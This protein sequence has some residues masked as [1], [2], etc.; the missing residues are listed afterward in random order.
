MSA[1]LNELKKKFAVFGLV[2]L[3]MG[4]LSLVTLP[5]E[6]S[7]T[8]S[9]LDDDTPATVPEP[10]GTRSDAHK[11][12]GYLELWDYN[13]NEPHDGV[14]GDGDPGDYY[15]FYLDSTYSYFSIYLRN[16]YTGYRLEYINTTLKVG[17]EAT[18]VI[19]VTSKYYNY[20]YMY[21]SYVRE[22]SYGFKIDTTA[23]IQSFQLVLDIEFVAVNENYERTSRTGRIYFDI[24]LSSRLRTNDEELT[25]RGRDKSGYYTPIYSG[26]RNMYITLMDAYSGDGDLEDLTVN[27][28][29][30]STFTIE[31]E[32][33]TF[34]DFDTYYY[35][36]DDMVWL[37]DDAGSVDKMPDKFYGTIEISYRKDE[38][39]IKERSVPIALEIAKTPIINLD[40]QI[41]ESEIGSMSGVDYISNVAIYQGSTSEMFSLKFQ[42]DGNLDLKDVKIELYTDNAAFFFKSKFYYDEGNYAYKR[43]YGKTI[44]LG[45]IDVGHFKTE[46]I[47]TEVIKNLP[48]GLYKIPIK[49]SAKYLESEHTEI[50]VEE[51]D[52]HET[53][54][55]ARSVTNEGFTPFLL[56][57]VIEGDNEFDTTEPDM[58]A[59]TD[60]V[61][62]PGMHNVKLSVELTNLENYRLNNVNV[63]IDVGGSSP[64]QPLNEVDRTA[65]KL[66][67]LEK[68]FAIYS[69]SD[70]TF[71]N[72]YTVHFMVDIYSEA[73]SGVNEVPITITCLDPY[74]QERSTLVNVPLNINPIPPRIILIDASTNN[75]EPDDTFT[76]K[77]RVYN[78]GGCNAKNVRLL[79][80]GSSN[81]FTAEKSI[82]GPKNINKEAESEFEF[83]I[84]A[85]EVEP[86][87]IYSSSVLVGYEDELGNLISFDDSA[88]QFITL[89][90][91][92]PEPEEPWRINEGIAL[93]ILG[94]F[95]LFSTLLF[96]FFRARTGRKTR[97]DTLSGGAIEP[98]VVRPS[99]DDKGK[100]KIDARFRK[101]SKA[102][103]PS[104]PQSRGGDR[105]GPAPTPIPP[106]A[107]APQRPGGAQPQP[108]ATTSQAHGSQEYG[109]R[110]PPRSRE[111]DSRYSAGPG[112]GGRGSGQQ[113]PPPQQ[114]QG[115]P[116]QPQGPGPG[117]GQQQYQGQ[118]PYPQ[119]QQQQ[120]PQ[121]NYYY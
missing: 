91:N 72:K 53:I 65:S 118:R 116:P 56:V 36:N 62:R 70:P 60:T 8:V 109:Q 84:K 59:T 39:L 47:S 71:S 13:Y 5:E 106:P 25:L 96:G 86:G 101:D 61:L 78:C 93:V 3:L 67:A 11:I 113:G 19:K 7:A 49:Y 107:P 9:E 6:T 95:I 37:L 97:A 33:L 81:L 4:C 64:L 1:I 43:A 17:S 108:Q 85:G 50:E 90:V 105:R 88:E 2:F 18:A 27:L 102:P 54:I 22:F 98:R 68:D 45:D 92:E 31:N 83:N 38:T 58:L 12:P 120:R 42:N 14:Y 77:V 80:N 69:A 24:Q 48:P 75:I 100:A 74:N 15:K 121:Q 21:S 29:L 66:D 23:R 16:I 63:R 44:E 114:Q 104:Q 40:N 82:Q 41:D 10:A 99:A 57:N 28:N 111:G 46:D 32:L 112:W 76:L 52:V 51:N 89:R 34:D 73:T 20:S 87:E 119:Q 103:E 35:N 30:P 26:S 55:A 117:A 79:F 115:P 94:L 110:P